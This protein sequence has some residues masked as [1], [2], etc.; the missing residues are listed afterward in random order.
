MSFLLKIVQGPNAGAEVALTEG[1][2]LSF[3]TSTECDIVLN[4]AS[5]A[6]QA[7]ELEITQERVVFIQNGRTL[8]LDPY[9]VKFVGTT[10]LVVGPLEGGWKDLLWPDLTATTTTDATETAEDSLV[11]E[12]PPQGSPKRS[13]MWRILICLLLLLLGGAI[14][15]AFWKYPDGS[16]AI[17]LRSWTWVKTTC[18]ALFS[19]DEPTPATTTTTPKV[20]LDAVAKAYGFTVSQQGAMTIATGDF[21]T[22]V[23]R[24]TA[25]A[26][27]YAAHPGLQLDFSDE[28]T[29]KTAMEQQL[30][31]LTEGRL[32]VVRVEGRKV[33]LSGTVASEAALKRYLTSIQTDVPKVQAMDCSQ[34]VV[35]VHPPVVTPTVAKRVSK[36]P[37]K[38]AS[39]PTK[40][41]T[42]TQSK[43][44]EMPVVGILSVPY[45]CLVLS[46][47]SR[48]MEG[49]R[50]NQYVIE[51]IAADHVILRGEQGSFVWRP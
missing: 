28:E 43:H 26:K 32:Q 48:A 15:F 31:L 40:P 29:L 47:G 10:A 51:T 6:P 11:E 33:S 17:T 46:D 27:A 30:D 19:S 3:G 24:L 16:K 7:F 9:H 1:V 35:P 20:S 34:V 14:G 41:T 8:K 36:K 12:A 4:D 2:T 50:F 37:P 22:R 5:L 13:R 49:A 44:P 45:P 42:S 21:K 25:T 39:A 23:D 18:G 38:V